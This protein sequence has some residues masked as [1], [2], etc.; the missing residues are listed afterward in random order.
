[1]SEWVNAKWMPKSKALKK[2]LLSL[3]RETAP[4]H[5][6]TCQSK[7]EVD[8]Y[9]Q[10]LESCAVVA[11]RTTIKRDQRPCS[12]DRKGPSFFRVSPRGSSG[13]TKAT[14]HWGLVERSRKDGPDERSVPVDSASGP[15]LFGEYE[16]SEHIT[17]EYWKHCVRY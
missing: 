10:L 14:T 9:T 17:I 1:M 2:L 13:L 12:V 15:S 6:W 3:S 7:H 16:K 4:T 8:I 11:G 5:D